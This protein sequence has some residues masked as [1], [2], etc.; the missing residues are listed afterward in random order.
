MNR[1]FSVARSRVV[2]RD[3]AALMH[4][5]TENTGSEGEA[6]SILRSLARLGSDESIHRFEMTP[7]APRATTLRRPCSGACGR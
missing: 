7:T 6:A 3:E 2:G 5:L 4:E 1:S